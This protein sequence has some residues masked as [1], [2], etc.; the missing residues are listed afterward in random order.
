MSKKAL[1]LV[2][3]ALASVGLVGAQKAQKVKI[4]DTK[5]GKGPKAAKGDIIIVRYTG[6]LLNGGVFDSNMFDKNKAP[7][8]LR[9]GEHQVIEGWETGLIGMQKDGER[10]LVIPPAL[11]YGSQAM[12][13]KIPANSTLDFTVKCLDIVKKADE[14]VFD[15][16]E[17]KAGTGK[18]ATANS[19]VTIIY[20]ATISGGFQFDEVT[21]AKPL[22][23]SLKDPEY[24][25]AFRLGV[26]GMKEGGKRIVRI[27]PAI[28]FGEQGIP[29]SVPGKSVLYFEITLLKVKS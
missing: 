1:F 27:P 26:I 20:K 15:K 29:P 28:G 6:K 21:K 25:K 9:L 18:S 22:T 12:G 4:T 16:T 17:V 19:S 8:A 11:G 7:F 3:V 24:L 10:R 5:V 2:F 14:R 23:M 13:D